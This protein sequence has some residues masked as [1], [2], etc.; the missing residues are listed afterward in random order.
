MEEKTPKLSF[1]KAEKLCSKLIIEAIYQ[2]GKKIKQFPFMLNYIEVSEEYMMDFPVQIV[3][4]VPKRKVKNASGLNRLKRQIREAY[5][6][7][8]VNIVTEVVTNK[9]RLALFLI[10]IGKEKEN[11]AF[12]EKKIKVLLKQLQAEIE[13][14]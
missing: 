1:P 5:R 10:Y 2:N 4:S 7:N 12:I 6:L 11:Y 13:S 9:K 3:I 8:K 14:T